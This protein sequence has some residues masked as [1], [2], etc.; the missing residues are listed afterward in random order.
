MTYH[1][2]EKVRQF[3]LRLYN[4]LDIAPDQTRAGIM[5]YGGSIRKPPVLKCSFASSYNNRNGFRS[6]IKSLPYQG[7]SP[8]L[9][10][11]LY[12]TTQVLDDPDRYGHREDARN[13]VIHVTSGYDA[14]G[15]LTS[16]TKYAGYVK[17]FDDTKVYAIGFG[18][19]VYRKFVEPVNSS[20]SDRYRHYPK[21]LTEIL[22]VADKI[23]NQIC[24]A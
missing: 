20:P 7:Q 10:Y 3:T 8:R 12:D 18:P 21:T 15:S 17:D 4:Q 9:T 2:W 16:L 14:Y 6:C 19:Y 23:G 11:S 5:I 13:V 1:Y 24:D 22:G